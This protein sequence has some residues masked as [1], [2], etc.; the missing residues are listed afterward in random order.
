[1]LTAVGNIIDYENLTHNGLLVNIL[2]AS[3]DSIWSRY[4]H[5]VESTFQA[6]HYLYDIKQTS[7]MVVI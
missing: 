1:M 4:Y 7:M 2:S 5:F 6:R 3:G